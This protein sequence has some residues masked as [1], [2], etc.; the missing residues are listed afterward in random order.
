[1]RPESGWAWRAVA[2]VALALVVFTP[3]TADAGTL[4]LGL[5][6][7]EYSSPDAGVRD[8]WLDRSVDAGAR[9]VG[10]NAVW[11]LIAPAIPG[12]GFDATSPSDPRYDWRALDTR[13]RDAA[14]HGLD[15]VLILGSAP[16][17]AEGPGR[18]STAAAPAG[19]WKPD[20]RAFGDFATALARR[21]SGSFPDPVN[22]GAPLP[23]VRYYRI[24]NEP[25]LTEYLTPQWSGSRPASPKRYRL[26]LNAAYASIKGVNRSN[27]V[28]APGTAPYG[29][30]PGEERMRPVT[31]LRSMFCL[32][33]RLG[34]ARCDAP[35]HLD[36]LAH[37]PI[38]QG[39]PTRHAVNRNDATTSDLPRFTRVLRAARRHGRVLPRG[40]KPLWVTEF[41]WASKP[42]SSYG[43]SPARQA[44][45]LE[46]ALYLFWK[47]RVKVAMWLFLRDPP[48]PELIVSS[49]LYSISD[50]P[51]P[52]LR[53]FRF[54]F[55]VDRA[56]RPGP[57]AR[58]WGM[59]PEAGPVTIQVR[60]AGGWKT[61]K[62]FAHRRPGVF[63][64]NLPVPRG[65][66]LRALTRSGQASLP[67]KVAR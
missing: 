34:P 56:A 39:A 33:A 12:V 51:K 2:A 26:L 45:W 57:S 58:A 21:Y 53:A 36:V 11:S 22:A 24:W 50:R 29:D 55:V 52:A 6:A 61:V 44:R 14:A 35:A 19:T 9:L 38:N 63:V 30:K 8:F 65:A 60:R 7:G 16:E 27:L 62:R 64:T 43:V 54:P 32:T 18:P 10:T 4:R 59:A 67:W 49:G 1:M 17:W 28:I 48:N 41:W 5:Y 25:N 15:T 23:R 66:T 3:A 20:P 37:H 42:P 13:V 31:F 46:Q 40:A 47:Q